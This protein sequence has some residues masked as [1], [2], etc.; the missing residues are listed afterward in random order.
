MLERLAFPF[1]F[2]TSSVAALA[3]IVYAVLFTGVL[4]FDDLP[5]VPHN[6]RGLDLDRGYEALS[7]VRG[8]STCGFLR[9]RLF[10]GHTRRLGPLGKRFASVSSVQRCAEAQRQQILPQRQAALSGVCIST[11]FCA[12]LTALESQIQLY[13]N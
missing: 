3:V 13:L 5:R 10:K 12:E 1:K 4:V 9:S 8:F 2:T 6:T 11:L 7:T